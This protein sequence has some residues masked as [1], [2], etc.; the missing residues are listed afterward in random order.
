MVVILAFVPIFILT[1]LLMLRPI[2][3]LIVLN[4]YSNG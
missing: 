2:L 4:I 1:L 3:K